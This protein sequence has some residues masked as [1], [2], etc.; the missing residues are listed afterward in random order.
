MTAHWLAFGPYDCPQN[1][2]YARTNHAQLVEQPAGFFHRRD[3]SHWVDVDGVTPERALL[4][5]L[6]ATMEA[7]ARLYDKPGDLTDEE[8]AL[9]SKLEDRRSALEDALQRAVSEKLGLDY[10]VLWH[11]ITP[12]GPIPKLP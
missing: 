5:D 2:P 10:A 11:A 12:S 4:N 9:T 8:D 7:I 6:I 1:A 3:L